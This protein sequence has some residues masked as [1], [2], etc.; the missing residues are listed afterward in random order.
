VHHA[1]LSYYLRGRA[2]RQ[3]VDRWSGG[4][5][6]VCIELV[7]VPW[8]CCACVSVSRTALVPCACVFAVCVRVRRVRSSNFLNNSRRPHTVGGTYFRFT[9]YRHFPALNT[10]RT[11]LFYQA[12]FIIVDREVRTRRGLLK[13]TA[14]AHT[15][16][17]NTALL[18]AH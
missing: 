2:R 16:V 3:T 18:K 11:L 8:V 13:A 4:V 17:A 10:Y 5:T 1:I 9:F 6:V 15:H 14:T 7:C 12:F